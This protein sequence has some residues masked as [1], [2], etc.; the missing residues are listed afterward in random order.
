MGIEILSIISRDLDGAEVL[1]WH[2]SPV[3]GPAKGSSIVFSGDPHELS[4]AEVFKQMS[5]ASPAEHP[6]AGW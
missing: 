5:P 3:D 4:L 1:T 2:S 6:P